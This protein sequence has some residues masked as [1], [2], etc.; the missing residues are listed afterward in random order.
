MYIL[1]WESKNSSEFLEVEIQHEY[2]Y[3]FF[4]KMRA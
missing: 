2:D 3:F 1:N 4:I